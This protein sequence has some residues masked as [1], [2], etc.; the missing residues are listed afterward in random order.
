VDEAWKRGVYVILDLHGAPG[1]ASPFQSSGQ[2]N[3]GRAVD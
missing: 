2:V 3:G 1:G